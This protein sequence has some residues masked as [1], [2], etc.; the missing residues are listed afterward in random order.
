MQDSPNKQIT[1]AT[2]AAHIWITNTHPREQE[3]QGT[4]AS[5]LELCGTLGDYGFQLCSF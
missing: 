2:Q 3:E 4:E 5:V 1:K